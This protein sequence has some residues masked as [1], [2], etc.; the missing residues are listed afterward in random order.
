MVCR[1]GRYIS[2]KRLIAH[3]PRAVHRRKIVVRPEVPGVGIDIDALRQQTRR[4]E[5]KD[6]QKPIHPAIH[7]FVEF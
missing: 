7:D 4:R 1:T 5:T 3:E 2:N 6:S